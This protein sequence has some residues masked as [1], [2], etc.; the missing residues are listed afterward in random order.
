VVYYSRGERAKR[1]VG[2]VV[3]NSIV[4]TDVKKIV[5]TASLLLSEG[6]T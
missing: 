1:G 4:R 3:H 2:I 6:Q 5:M